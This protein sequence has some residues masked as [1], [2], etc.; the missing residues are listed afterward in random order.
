[1]LPV[2]ICCRPISEGSQYGELCPILNS[3]GK[4]RLDERC[5]LHEVCEELLAVVSGGG[6]FARRSLG[7]ALMMRAASLR[8]DSND[9]IQHKRALISLNNCYMDVDDS[10]V[11]QSPAVVCVCDPS[12]VEMIVPMS[13]R[14]RYK[15]TV[16]QKKQYTKLLP[17]S[18]PNINRFSIFFADRLIGKFATNLC[19]CIPPHLKCVATLPC[20][21]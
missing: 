7:A 20:E 3:Y 10:Q 18:S 6:S 2:K 11:H 19:L 15:Y 1:M 4:S 12:K 17:I 8:P 16:S 14:D 21:I 9:D 13:R 5:M